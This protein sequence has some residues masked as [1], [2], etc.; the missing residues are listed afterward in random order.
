M[1]YID[2]S[3]PYKKNQDGVGKE[4]LFHFKLVTTETSQP[5][6]EAAEFQNKHV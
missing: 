5:W 4:A 2:S 6:T 3:S 1:C